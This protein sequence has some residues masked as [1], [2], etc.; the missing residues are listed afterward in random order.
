MSTPP[1]TRDRDESVKKAAKL[2]HENNIGSVVVVEKDGKI[3]GM[4]T[5]KDRVFAV[6]H[7]KVG[8]NLPCWMLMTENPMTVSPETSI[9]DVLNTMR[10]ANIRHLSIVDKEGKLT[11]VLSLRDIGKQ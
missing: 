2:M 3:A 10:E 11:D 1:I 9:V 5:K 8:K 6:A 7:D 4:L